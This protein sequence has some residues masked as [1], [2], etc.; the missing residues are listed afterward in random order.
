VARLSLRAVCRVLRLLAPALGRKRAPWPQTVLNW[1]IRLS[2]VRLAAARGLRGLPLPQA[3]FS[4]GLLWM[5][6]LS[7]GLGAGKILAVLALAAHHH[8][9]WGPSPSL[10][11]VHCIGGVVADAWTG[12]AIADRLA[13][14]IAQ[15]GRPAADLQRRWQRAAQSR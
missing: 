14:L 2:M 6:D 15:M 4:H 10:E 7:M 13:R 5:I 3:P 8:Q 12:E 9:L 11:P 1:G